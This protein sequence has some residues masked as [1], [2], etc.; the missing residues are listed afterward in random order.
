MSILPEEEIWKEFL[1][2]H[3]RNPNV[4]RLYEGISRTGHPELLITGL[5][6][7]WLLKRDSLYSGRPGLGVEL[8]EGY[9]GPRIEPY[10]FRE[11]PKYVM[12]KIVALVEEGIDPLKAIKMIIEHE[13]PNI[14]SQRPISIDRIR[15][16]MVMEGP[17]LYTNRPLP[18]FSKR[19]MELD[20]KLELELKKLRSRLD[21]YVG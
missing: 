11:A 2:K 16:P 10:G 21:T 17:V 3:K 13:I 4:W 18:Y 20:R 8:D 1:K 5:K 9:R 14:L 6:K 15:S 19:Q 12:K 7:S